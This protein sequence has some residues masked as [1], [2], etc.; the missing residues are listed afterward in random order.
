MQIIVCRFYCENFIVRISFYSI[1][2]IL[3]CGFYYA[4]S[5]YSVD[6][7]VRILSADSIV[8]IPL[9]GF[10]C[11]D[12]VI[13]VL[14]CRFHCRFHCVDFHRTD[15][16]VQILI[17]M[18]IP[19]CGFNCVDSIVRMPIMWILLCESHCAKFHCADVYYADFI[20]IPSC[21]C[22]VELHC[23]KCIVRIASYNRLLNFSFS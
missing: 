17:V 21:N 22:V 12:S 8:R 7:I 3:S 9:C 1:M 5:H 4:D 6:S 16:I 11:A 18:W 10:H 20:V 2:R 13:R 15:S 14:L 19:S 23:A